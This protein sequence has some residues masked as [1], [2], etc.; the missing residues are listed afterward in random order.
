MGY[1]TLSNDFNTINLNAN[2]FLGGDI[3]LNYNNILN[4]NGLTLDNIYAN[5]G[6]D[7]YFNNNVNFNNY[8]IDNCQAIRVDYIYANL[9][10]TPVFPDGLQVDTIGAYV[11]GITTFNTGIDMNTN[12]ISN[13]NNINPIT[14]YFPNGS[15]INETNIGGSNYLQLSNQTVVQSNLIIVGGSSDPIL[16]FNSGKTGSIDYYTDFKFSDNINL[17]SNTLYNVNAISSISISTGT[18]HTSSLTV[19]TINNSAFPLIQFG[20]GTDNNTITLPKGYGNTNYQILL[21]QRGASAIIPLYSSNITTSNFY[22]GGSVGSY[23]FSWMTMG[24]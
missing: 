2:I 20:S 11:T 8:G 6:T 16:Y 1:L 22:V 3:N 4:V 19:S 14:I 12:S 5:T 24:F 18:L 15:I 17:N 21:T 7:V 9:N 23:Q 10:G 13:I